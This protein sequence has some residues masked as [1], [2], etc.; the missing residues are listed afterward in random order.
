MEGRMYAFY[1]QGEDGE[2]Y[3]YQ[4]KWNGVSELGFRSSAP[5]G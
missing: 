2:I 3:H 4:V 1:F 5:A